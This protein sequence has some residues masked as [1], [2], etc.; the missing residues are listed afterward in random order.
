MKFL[1]KKQK[2]DDYRVMDKFPGI[3]KKTWKHNSKST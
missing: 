2:L 1:F 3:A